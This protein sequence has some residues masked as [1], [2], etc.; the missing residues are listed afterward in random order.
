MGWGRLGRG[1][2]VRVLQGQDQVLGFQVQNQ[3]YGLEHQGQDLDLL[4]WGGVGKGWEKPKMGLGWVCWVWVRQLGV[5]R[6]Q[7]QKREV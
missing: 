6:V 3:S 1:R 7:N 2:V 5:R 4:G